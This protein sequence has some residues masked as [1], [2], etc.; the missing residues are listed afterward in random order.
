MKLWKFLFFYIFCYSSFALAGGAVKLEIGEKAFGVLLTEALQKIDGSLSAQFDFTRGS[1]EWSLVTYKLKIATYNLELDCLSDSE[2]G[3]EL[4]QKMQKAARKLAAAGVQ[5][6]EVHVPLKL[7]VSQKNKVL[8]A[9]L[10]V[11]FSGLKILG[12]V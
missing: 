10:K 2:Q 12:T 9:V 1:K 11:D 4:K 8:Q 5:E 6:L 3:I 7:N